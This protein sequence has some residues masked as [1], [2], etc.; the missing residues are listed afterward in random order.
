VDCDC[1][2]L[3]DKRS[4]AMPKTLNKLQR[5]YLAYVCRYVS[6]VKSHKDLSP[7]GHTALLMMNQDAG[8]FNDEYA[9]IVDDYI[10]KL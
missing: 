5:D 10:S 3:H 4:K 9:V 1:K 8:T 7:E 6:D 2:A